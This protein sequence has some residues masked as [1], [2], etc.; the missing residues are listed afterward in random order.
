MSA[1]RVSPTEE[2]FMKNWYRSGGRDTRR[3]FKRYFGYDAKIINP[4]K[5]R[6]CRNC[7]ACRARDNKTT[8]TQLLPE[9]V[10]YTSCTFA[11]EIASRGALRVSSLRHRCR[12]AVELTFMHGDA[13][14]EV[15]RYAGKYLT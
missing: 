15:S 2:D 10:V 11:R 13:R 12:T 14:N 7:D 8:R 5:S 6:S 9:S 1:R 3:R 4:H